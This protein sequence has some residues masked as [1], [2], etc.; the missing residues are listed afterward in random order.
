MKL[1]ILGTKS[2]GTTINGNGM[3]LTGDDC[4]LVKSELVNGKWEV[5][6]NIT[7]KNIIINKGSI[8]L[9]GQGVNG[10]GELVKESSRN[11]NH[12]IDC[13]AAAP[14]SIIFENIT[15]K[16]DK[17]IPFYVGP[18]CTRI[19]LRNCK[20]TGS[21]VATAIY[22][23]C[24]SA[25]NVIENNLIETK[26]KREMLAVDGSAYNVIRGNT[27]VNPDLG[28][29]YLY[30][31]SG[32]GGTI[33]HQPPIKNLIEGNTFKYSVMG[34]AMSL[35][36]PTI[37]IG[38]RSRFMQY[39]YQYRDEDKGYRFGSSINNEDLASGNKVRNNKP[40]CLHVRN[41]EK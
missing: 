30:R 19:T 17:R 32:E 40:C 3:V 27:F 4:L 18:G 33:R 26:V 36:H 2:N 11:K 6:E 16:A 31:N 41:W 37:W 13:Q 29:I 5:P 23:D 34:R 9:V 14:R 35:L 7:I 12:T 1:E 28:G 21:S 39:F 38:A 8:R 15:V 20:L 25:N 10:Q 22:L 24:E